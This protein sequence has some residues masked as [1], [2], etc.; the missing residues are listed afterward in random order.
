MKKGA[1]LVKKTNASADS[2]EA[3]VASPAIDD[4]QGNWQRVVRRRSFL[5]GI[6]VAGATMLVMS[7]SGAATQA[8][9]F[10]MYDWFAIP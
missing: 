9:G 6:G 1:F 10:I 7:V 3:R 8:S 2:S 5:Q 4:V